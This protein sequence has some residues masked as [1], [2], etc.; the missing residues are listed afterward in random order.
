MAFKPM[1][2]QIQGGVEL[3]ADVDTLKTSYDAAK[4]ITTT[5]KGEDG[6]TYNADEL[7]TKIQTD[8]TSL[9]SKTQEAIKT[10]VDAIKNKV[11]KDVV[12]IQVEA[13]YSAGDGEGSYSVTLP[14]DFDT[15][16][17]SANKET[18][19]SVYELD[20]TAVIDET[21]NQITIN[22]TDGT[23]SGYP[24]EVDEA[25]SAGGTT[26]YKKRTES[27]DIKFFPVGTFTLDTLSED[28]M[29]DNQELQLLSYD[30]AINKI[31]TNLAQDQSLI[32][33][34]S[35]LVGEEAVAEQ[36]K[37]KTDALQNQIDTLNGTVSGHTTS[38]ADIAT[39][40][41]KDSGLNANSKKV[42]N[43][44]DGDV[45]D[46]STDAINGKQ[47]F[48]TKTEL[49]SSIEAKDSAMNTRMVTVEGY[50]KAEGL[51]AN[52][53]KVINVADGEIAADNKEAINGGQLYTVK[54]TLE[55]ADTAIQESV[56]TL[57]ENVTTNHEALAG[58]VTAVEAYVKET[59]I[60]ANSKKVVNVADATLEADNKDAVN[61]GQLFTVDAAYKAADISLQGN[62]DTLS[63][64]VES[65]HTELDDKIDGVDAKVDTNI[66]DIAKLKAATVTIK[67]PK[68]HVDSFDMTGEAQTVFTL[69]AVPNE[70]KVMAN[71]NG[72]VY[73]EDTGAFTVD[74]EQK[75]VTWAFGAGAGG[76]D[77]KNDIAEKVVIR[78]MVDEDVVATLTIA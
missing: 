21:G 37:K 71:I 75:T 22:L 15:K 42:V 18:P 52:N 67:V 26:V 9:D 14:E 55:A 19:V 57:E 66:T 8:I 40:V 76:F 31:I 49:T 78:Y 35:A 51:D 44:L 1:L 77:L 4:V 47:L 64:T 28:Y 10:A 3:R 72:I 11:V 53:K 63:E 46:S 58:R 33:K 50:V 39:Y 16:V 29:L 34:I 38:L 6:G 59:G 30:Q 54:T 62:I 73:E 68:V 45:S 36:I 48:A 41:N 69:T 60:N 27:F 70:V 17:P 23:L 2:S 74:R 13:T 43:V 25:A 61:G 7:L 5:S 32:D 56:T 20:N 12:R 24:C 65:Y